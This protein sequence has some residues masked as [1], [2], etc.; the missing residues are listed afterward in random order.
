MNDFHFFDEYVLRTPILPIKFYTSVFD[1][2]SF[3][4]L[5]KKVD[6]N[7]VLRKALYLA[8]PDFCSQLN[9][10]K[11]NPEGFSYD[12]VQRIETTL[13]KYISRIASR[14]TPFGLFA[15]C[16][17][18]SFSNVNSIELEQLTKHI[19]DLQLDNK[20]LTNFVEC[21]GTYPEIKKHLKYKPNDTLYSIGDYVRYV[22][23][24]YENERRV[25]RIM[26][27]TL[28][29]TL[30][31][32]IKE[33]ESTG[34]KS[35]DEL[36]ELIAT[37][38]T[39]YYEARIYINKLIESQI[40]VST[41]G[42]SLTGKTNFNGL[43]G[44]LRKANLEEEYKSFKQIYNLLKVQR[45]IH[46]FDLEVLNKNV[47]SLANIMQLKQKEK[48]TIQADSYLSYHSN[49]LK[50]KIAYKTKRA[51]LFLA[52][53]TK[54]HKIKNLEL[55]KTAFLKKYDGRELSLSLVLDP[56]LGIG[57]PNPEIKELDSH[58]LLDQ[59]NLKM[60]KK[61]RNYSWS[62]NDT[63]LQEKLRKAKESGDSIINIS[64]YNINKDDTNKYHR[65]TLSAMVEV[66]EQDGNDLIYIDAINNVSATK[67]LGRFTNGNEAIYSHIKE[68][69]SKEES[70]YPDNILAE[71][72]HAPESRTG[73]IIKRNKLRDYEIPYL[74]NNETSINQINSNDL[75]VSVINDKIQLR[76]KKLNK[77]VFPC[78]SNAHNYSKNALPIYQFLC[79]LQLQN[80]KAIYDFSW[81]NLI[82]IYDYFPRVVYDSV[83]L[84]KQ[85]W[86]VTKIKF[87]EFT[88]S[89]GYKQWL[90][91]NKI[92]EFVLL[93]EGDNTLLL[94]T[95]NEISFIIIRKAVLK[96]K[97]VFIEEC[98]FDN[99]SVVKD[100]FN[101]DYANQ[102]IISYS[103]VS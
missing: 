27:V 41:Q 33:S 74:T 21:L 22:Y 55:F 19:V 24:V 31:V 88:F 11:L 89:N 44:I 84:K 77:F 83:I 69:V 60:V 13:L 14:C 4:N 16:T 51:I 42:V 12:K 78:L 80:V 49:T 48:F 32:V 3:D 6:E 8:S 100:E 68:I 56:E 61:N 36:V 34:S 23:Y 43:L 57:Y 103:S 72:V 71:I 47:M 35:I 81:G 46:D 66:Y 86:A 58:P 93:V 52:A 70:L 15:G 37:D 39:E 62:E 63:Y 9:D 97:R 17:V 87:Q 92:P 73:N 99:T 2:Y 98:L 10:Y 5:I 30:K 90:L 76:S 95:L 54:Q 59:F 75:M 67:L 28:T 91:A 26:N 65:V 1:D 7:S 20:F 18:G 45:T 101:N 85:M 50:R 79:D 94:H 25:H 40:L 82:D 64:D 29:D 96:Y 102:F 38:E 53:F